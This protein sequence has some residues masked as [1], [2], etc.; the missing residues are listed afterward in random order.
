MKSKA[1]RFAPLGL[2]L[3]MLS[4]LSSIV[5]YILQRQWNLAL[6]ISL[7]LIIVGLA[8]F[9]ILDPSKVRQALT[10]RSARYGS[11]ALVLV[12]AF[13]GILVVMNYFV[14][15]NDKHW[16]LT[17]DKQNTLAPETLEVLDSLE[18]PVVIQAFY[19]PNLSSDTAMILLD[20]YTYA[21]KGKI[22][23]ELIDPVSN[24]VTATEQNITQ[25]GTVVLRMGVARQQITT[26]TEDELTSALVRLMN[27]SGRVVYFLTGHGELSVE[28]SGDTTYSQLKA[29][30]EG[31]NYT[32]QTLNLLAT[33]RIPADADVILIGGPSISLSEAEISH[34]EE[35]QNNGGALIV[36]A[37]PIPLTQIGD[38]ADLLANYL[39]ESWGV[40]LGK[41]IVV[42]L[43]TN[44]A[45]VAYASRY[46]SHA[47][48][49]KMQ[50]LASVFPTARSV[51]LTNAISSGVSQVLLIYTADQ[52]W[53]ET[54][55]DS[56]AEGNIEADPDT[57]LIGQISIA[58]AA[59][60]FNSEARL[61]VFGDSEFASDAYFTAF[62]NADMIVNSID[63]ASGEEDMI[64][65]SARETTT[66]TMLMPNT[67]TLGLLFLGS[68]ILLPGI[69]LAGGITA[70]VIRRRRG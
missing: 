29:R 16:D 4:G 47:I 14:Y 22:S 57:D 3:A 69:V 9:A 33:N 63:W 20:K 17:E 35:Y 28:G 11:N 25:D 43:Q 38:D 53:A 23:Y 68:M 26:I 32:I 45:F 27:P 40:V 42:D 18:D 37:E 59:E 50:N 54:N 52:A 19:S 1:R 41:D 62:G 60:N 65:L 49:D 39:A 51:T 44:Q 7:G 30:L 24:P 67:L 64:N 12:F 10:G 55:L 13:M 31:K 56:L 58:A 6:Q 61:V 8:L 70:W 21:S 46:G 66:R 34:L 15:Q 48:T 36:L 2:W 5:I